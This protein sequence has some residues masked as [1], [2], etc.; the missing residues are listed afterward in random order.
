MYQPFCGHEVADD[1]TGRSALQSWYPRCQWLT[2]ALQRRKHSLKPRQLVSLVQR[3]VRKLGDPAHDRREVDQQYQSP[4]ASDT[5]SIDVQYHTNR[6]IR[7]H[8]ITL[9]NYLLYANYNTNYSTV[10]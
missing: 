10:A 8:Y 1:G 3:C 5:V 9:K 6:T 2:I 7:L 4:S